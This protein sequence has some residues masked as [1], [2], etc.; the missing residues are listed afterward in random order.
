LL[1]R[2]LGLAA[3]TAIVVGEVIGTGVFLKARVMICNVDGSPMMVFTAWVAAGA[4]S[5]AGALTYAELMAMR[6]RAAGEYVVLREA[7]GERWAFL[8]GWMQSTIGYGGG[9]AAKAAAFAIFLNVV[10]GG[11]LALTDFTIRLPGFDIPFGGL[12]LVALVTIAAMTAVN[13]AAVSVNGRLAVWLSVAKVGTILAIGFGALTLADGSWGRAFAGAP[14]AIG[15]SA[16]WA[17]EGVGESARSGL[18]GFGAAMLG[19]LWA[20]DGWNNMAAVAGEVKEPQ[21]NIPIGLIGGMALVTVLYLFVN[22][23]YFYVL[24]AGDVANIPASSSV[25]TETVRRFLGPVAVTLVG[26]AMLLS[27]L[28]TMHAGLLAGAR[29]PYAMALDGLFFRRMARLSP[30]SHVPA[31]SVMWLGALAAIMALSGSFDALTNYV[32]FSAFVFYMMV[33]ASVFVFRRRMPNDDRPYRTWGYPVVP[34]LFVVAS[35]FLLVNTVVTAPRESLIG[36]A[37]IA[38][39]L[40]AYEYWKRKNGAERTAR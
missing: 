24:P 18:A 33:T 34:A 1:V 37:L 36:L 35:A 17:C 27:T 29:F 30:G 20:Y 21:R 3:A 11:A 25:A 26:V 19:A 5:L 12:Q 31:N 28:G 39:G 8:Y 9:A 32:I 7:Y 40:P 14:S 13:C 6:P 2:G 4:L 15:E 23:A 38:A 16:T 10:T 22:A